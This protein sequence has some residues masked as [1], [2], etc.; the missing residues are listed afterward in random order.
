E[1]YFRFNTFRNCMATI[2]IRNGHRCVIEG[3]YFIEDEGQNIEGGGVRLVGDDHRV[4]N[5]YFEGL[6]GTGV[7]APVVLMNG[8]R[9]ELFVYG[10][11]IYEQVRRAF[12]AH[13][14]FVNC[15]APFV[16]GALAS[17]L[18]PDPPVDCIIVHNAV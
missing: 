7:F 15:E 14:T 17:D 11:G 13:N 9:P 8:I 12:I 4:I 6:T 5:N 1:N 18:Y 16:V 3:N 2:T 10:S